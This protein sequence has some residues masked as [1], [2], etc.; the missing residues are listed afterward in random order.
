M[1]GKGFTLVELLV[2]ISILA[3]LTTI[4]LI[5]YLGTQSRARDARR[6][7]DLTTI[8]ATLEQ[9]HADQSYYPTY[10]STP[11]DSEIGKVVTGSPGYPLKSPP[12]GTRTYSNKLPLDPMEGSYRDLN[13]F[14]YIYFAWTPEVICQAGNAYAAYTIYLRP[15]IACGASNNCTNYCVTSLLENTANSSKD[16]RCKIICTN[17]VLDLSSSY[18]LMLASP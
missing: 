12:N 8:Q 4:A 1:R 15:G 6:K 9:Y 10:S 2:T 13:M 17:F 16:D 7:S 5:Y 18:D 14:T 3:I 11:A